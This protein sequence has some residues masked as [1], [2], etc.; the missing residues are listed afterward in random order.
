MTV[1]ALKN[2]I[3]NK[4][5]YVKGDVFKM[6]DSDVVS[7]ENRHWVIRLLQENSKSAEVLQGLPP[8]EAKPSRGNKK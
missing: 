3:Y 8:L 4:T 5:F 6:K 2:L 1:K 7:Y